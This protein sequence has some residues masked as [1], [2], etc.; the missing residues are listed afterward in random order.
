MSIAL[1]PQVRQCAISSVPLM[2]G[3]VVKGSE[4]ISSYL[5]AC[6]FRRCR[7]GPVLKYCKP[8]RHLFLHSL[9]VVHLL[10]D[11]L[12]TSALSHH[13]W[14]VSRFGRRCSSPRSSGRLRLLFNPFTCSIHPKSPCRR[15]AILA[16]AMDACVH[17]NLCCIANQQEHPINPRGCEKRMR[18]KKRC[19]PA[20]PL[21]SEPA[22]Q[23]GQLPARQQLP[24]AHAPVQHEIRAAA[25]LG[26]RCLQSVSAV[27]AKP[28]TPPYLLSP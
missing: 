11:H 18:R 28:N 21:C 2:S 12:H 19:T 8:S 25:S 26:S 9:G 4:V 1:F 22:M 3:I 14:V 6:L 10:L 27:P 5:A 15:L 23:H 13:H 24:G 16:T 17:G 20:T 7:T